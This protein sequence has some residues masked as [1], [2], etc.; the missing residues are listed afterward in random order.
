[1]GANVLNFEV[2]IMESSVESEV[3][4]N[5]NME[6]SVGAKTVPEG[7]DD[8]NVPGESLES[9][10]DVNTTSTDDNGASQFADGPNETRSY[11]NADSYA[12]RT[13]RKAGRVSS[14]KPTWRRPTHSSSNDMPKRPRTALFTPSRSTSARSV[15]EALSMAHIDASDIQR[16]KRKMNSEVVITFKS[17]DVKE[18]FL[19][20]NALTVGEYSYATQD[21]DRPMTFLT[22]YDAPFELS[23]LTIIRPLAPFCEVVHY[24][25]GKFDFMPGVYNGLRHYRVRVTKPGL[26]QVLSGLVNTRFFLKH[27]GQVP[28]CRRCSLAGHFSNDCNP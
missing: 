7:T 28:T 13:A 3:V 26:F 27:D 2:W 22:I 5:L 12:S 21:I 16:I 18:K 4:T 8:P 14:D 19:R 24:R 10:N 6:S 23:N 11:V 20:L 25:R 15:F 9:V 17:V 1:M